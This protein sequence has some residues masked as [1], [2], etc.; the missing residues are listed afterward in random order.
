MP[1]LA[2]CTHPIKHLSLFERSKCLPHL[3]PKPPRPGARSGGNIR[4]HADGTF[5]FL[6]EICVCDYDCG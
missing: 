1:I 3:C 2:V 5:G 6:C 4:F